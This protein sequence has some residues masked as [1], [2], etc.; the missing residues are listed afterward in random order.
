M[1]TNYRKMETAQIRKP[2]ILAV[3][4]GVKFSLR[5]ISL[6]SLLSTAAAAVDTRGGL[7]FH[8]SRKS[9][10][11]LSFYRLELRLNPDTSAKRGE[12]HGSGSTA[13]EREQ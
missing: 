6:I 13:A 9:K 4:R 10:N 2:L 1:E 8:R 11:G 5:L 12:H 3:L 7:C